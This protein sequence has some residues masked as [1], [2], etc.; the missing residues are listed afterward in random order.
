MTTIW[1]PTSISAHDLEPHRLSGNRVQTAGSIV[2]NRWFWDFAPV[3]D[4]DG[5]CYRI[6]QS[7]VWLALT[8]PI[9]G[10]PSERHFVASLAVL[11]FAKGQWKF[12]GELMLRHTHPGNREWAGMAIAR[13]S[14]LR[15][16]FTSAGSR[17]RERGYQQRLWSASCPIV[18]L[19]DPTADQPWT[20]AREV[21]QAAEGP[22]LPADQEDGQPGMIR[23]F[24]DPFY[25]TAGESRSEHLVF[26]ASSV[27]V[28]SRY[29]GAIGYA[30]FS[31]STDSW[32]HRGAII[33][34]SDVA[35]EL[36]RAHVIEFGGLYYLFWSTPAYAFRMD[37]GYPTGLY[38]AVA[39]RL[40]GK[41]RLLNGHGLVLTNPE[42]RPF[43]QYSWFVSRDLTVQGFVDLPEYPADRLGDGPPDSQEK[44]AG[45]A[46]PRCSL[47]LEGELA[48]ISPDKP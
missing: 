48:R 38:G 37:L 25:F 42:N 13:E 43:E 39:E 23:A 29:N 19:E 3:L 45:T 35:T 11:Y 7:E 20:D 47:V 4:A 28:T 22:Y 21:L 2:S 44:F 34:S 36:E 12:L 24:R 18:V 14:T 27:D 6:G 32:E 26:T 16:Y 5:A 31:R 10:D 1:T 30:E 33:V 17:D 8:A 9:S 40:D 41:F 15:V 46:G